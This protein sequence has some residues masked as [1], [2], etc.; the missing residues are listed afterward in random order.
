MAADEHRS[1]TELGQLLLIDRH[2]RIHGII[3]FYAMVPMNHHAPS[4]AQWFPARNAGGDVATGRVVVRARCH[5]ILGMLPRVLAGGPLVAQL[6]RT[7]SFH[8]RACSRAQ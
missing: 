7:Q 6:P 2:L 1:T 4:A 8:S 3:R 5:I